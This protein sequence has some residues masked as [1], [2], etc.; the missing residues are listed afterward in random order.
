MNNVLYR[1]IVTTLTA[2]AAVGIMHADTTNPTP[3]ARPT[4]GTL[5]TIRGGTTV[6]V[7]DAD[8]AIESGDWHDAIVW[9][10]D[11]LSIAG[12]TGLPKSRID[13]LDDSKLVDNGTKMLVTSSYGWCVMLDYATRK[14]LFYTTRTPNAHSADLLPGNMIAVA[15]SSG[16]GEGYNTVQLYDAARSD[17]KIAEYTFPKAHAAVWDDTTQRLYVAGERQIGIYRLS[18]TSLEIE[19]TVV[20]A[21]SNV[22]DLLLIKPGKMS[23]AGK[24]AYV[25]DVDQKSFRNIPFLIGRTALKSLNVSPYTG[26]IWYTDA[27]DTVDMGQ[28]SSNDLWWAP[29]RT[30]DGPAMSIKLPDIDVYKVRVARWGKPVE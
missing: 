6:Y 13:H 27:T 12:E 8:T 1:F 22:H 19:E 18:G 4:P 24:E 2:M 25:Y 20:T 11:A 21:K 26:E 28:W 3:P 14:L 30:A 10:W 5:L 9:S 7:I 23:I 16:T 15:C 29:G 17:V